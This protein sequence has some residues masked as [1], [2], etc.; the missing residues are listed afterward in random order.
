MA[1]TQ[2]LKQAGSKPDKGRNER[3]RTASSGMRRTVSWNELHPKEEPELSA[4][5]AGNISK[6]AS[7]Q[8]PKRLLQKLTH[9]PSSKVTR[10]P[11]L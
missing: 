1:T 2:L 10:H 7:L 9:P 3:L 4:A 11:S 5:S 8:A 6:Q